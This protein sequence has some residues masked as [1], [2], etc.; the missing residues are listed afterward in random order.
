[1]ELP[2][3][4]V[5]HVE[6]AI[7]L[8]FNRNQRLTYLMLHEFEALLFS[9]PVELLRFRDLAPQL[10]GV[11]NGLEPENINEHNSRAIEA[12]IEVIPSY[13]KTLHGPTAAKRIGLGVLRGKCPY[14]DNWVG[15]SEGLAG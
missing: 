4:R 14:F 6:N 3:D 9:D 8:K 13:R 11:M 1:V 2:R 7:Y 10:V 5:I 15:R 12:D